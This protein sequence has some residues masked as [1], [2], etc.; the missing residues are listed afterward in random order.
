MTKEE[1]QADTAKRNAY[2]DAM[3]FPE[4]KPPSAEAMAM[5]A[6]PEVIAAEIKRL[7]RAHGQGLQTFRNILGHRRELGMDGGVRE[8]PHLT[9]LMQELATIDA[10]EDDEGGEYEEEEDEEEELEMGQG[11][12]S[13]GKGSGNGNGSKSG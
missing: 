11:N 13:L 3:G 10:D 7:I 6:P 8:N 2:I 5:D 4:L 1:L 12:E 9:Q